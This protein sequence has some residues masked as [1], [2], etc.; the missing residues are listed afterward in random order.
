MLMK[1]KEKFVAR[2]AAE[3]STGIRG[4]LTG[5][6]GWFRLADPGSAWRFF[7]IAP[8]EV[9]YGNVGSEFCPRQLGIGEGEDA[10]A[11]TA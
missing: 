9:D 11:R 6:G 2:E 5:G 4:S 10:R 7:L 3:Y 1:T 8:E